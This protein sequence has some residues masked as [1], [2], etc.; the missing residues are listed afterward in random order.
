MHVCIVVC[1]IENCT[2]LFLVC[3]FDTH[4]FDTVTEFWFT[5]LLRIMLNVHFVCGSLGFQPIC[6]PC[7]T[8]LLGR[9]DET[10]AQD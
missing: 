9:C 7:A 5:H 2:K 8:D 1:H 10:H 6:A 4:W 3:D